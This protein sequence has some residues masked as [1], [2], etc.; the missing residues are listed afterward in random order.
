MVTFASMKSL[1]MFR[2]AQ[3]NSSNLNPNA[4]TVAAAN[5][6][7]KI[8][9]TIEYLMSNS[10]SFD[11][12]MQKWHTTSFVPNGTPI[13]FEPY[14]SNDGLT[15]KSYLP[16]GAVLVTAANVFTNRMLINPDYASNNTG[17]V[18]PKLLQAT[19]PGGETGIFGQTFEGSFVR[20]LAH[21][22]SHLVNKSPDLGVSPPPGVSIEQ[23]EATK[24]A[25]LP[26]YA[27][28]S[29]AQQGPTALSENIIMGELLGKPGAPSDAGITRAVY[30][31]REESA[32]LTNLTG[33][34]RVDRAIAGATGIREEAVNYN[35]ASGSLSDLI[36]AGG[37]NDTVSSGGGRDFV[38]GGNGADSL[39]GGDGN[40]NLYGGD[41]NDTLR[42]D[43]GND[44]LM[45]GAGI[46]SIVGGAGNDILDGHTSNGT[47]AD[48]LVGGDGAD[49]Y[50]MTSGVKGI[51]TSLDGMLDHYFLSWASGTSQITDAGIW[52]YSYS[53][54]SVPTTPF[55]TAAR[56]APLTLSLEEAIP[57]DATTPD[58]VSD[59]VHAGLATDL[60][61]TELGS[62]SV[63]GKTATG[64]D[65]GLILGDFNFADGDIHLD[66]GRE[67]TGKW[68]TANDDKMEGKS[69]A[70]L[71][72]G[73][74]G[75]DRIDGKSG[76]DEL[77][78]EAGNDKLEGSSGNDGLYGDRGDDR[79]DGGSGKDSLW[80]GSD[81]D[82]L[83]GGSG[84]DMLSGNQG[85]DRLDG[86]S[87][88]DRLIGGGGADW[89][90]GGSG[91]DTFV[92]AK[93][94]GLD[95]ITDFNWRND[96]PSDRSEA[97]HY[98]R[99]EVSGL[100]VTTFDD[101][102]TRA[103]ESGDDITFDFGTGDML[104]LLNT[105]VADLHAD[106]FLFIA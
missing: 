37:G 20:V 7:T 12:L 36:W 22:M 25:T 42:G 82:S 5:F 38:Y 53:W 14:V 99:I 69:R 50:Y 66:V 46:D 87:G 56:L 61:M 78:G 84:D 75:N 85:D 62:F 39:A 65:A 34:E 51:D 101:L 59:L 4:S 96:G 18:A 83:A 70:D 73:G 81:N 15:D 49:N 106:A 91:D 11:A 90:T 35:F 13:S 23:A 98:D 89:L 94:S 9:S 77:S 79:L 47:A 76:N 45:G 55:G 6:Q 28:T 58:T 44:V 88:D 19:S 57:G 63:A 92:F 16:F 102:L 104:K 30:A 26:A 8:Y 103:T 27:V 31:F 100:N 95:T 67:G 48:T 93:E 60:Q 2:F 40:D 74:E 10:P 33:G 80:G 64:E 97:W 3:Y 52:T 43:V 54:L 29:T 68:G 17:S 21:E 86:E 41:G 32:P 71:L 105:D 72:I 24:V 1:G